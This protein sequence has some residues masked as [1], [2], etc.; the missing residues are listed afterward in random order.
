VFGAQPI[1]LAILLADH[2]LSSESESKL[3][4]HKKDVSL[5]RA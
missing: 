1:S 5:F 4:R 3:V 2:H